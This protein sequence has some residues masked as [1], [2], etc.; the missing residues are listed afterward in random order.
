MKLKLKVKTNKNKRL[1]AW[2][3]KDNNYKESVQELLSFFKDQIKI[4]KIS[5]ITNY[6]IVYSE[7]PGI[8]LSLHSAIQDLIPEVSFNSEES[9]EENQLMSS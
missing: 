1:V 7:N 5:K 9:L 6:Y 4:L 3:Q 8:I 2:I